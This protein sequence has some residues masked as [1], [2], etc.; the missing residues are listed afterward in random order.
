[1][2]VRSWGEFGCVTGCQGQCR[3]QYLPSNKSEMIYLLLLCCCCSY[4]GVWTMTRIPAK[5][6]GEKLTKQ[7]GGSGEDSCPPKIT[8]CSKRR[9]GWWGCWGFLE[10]GI[11]MYWCDRGWLRL[12]KG[13]VAGRAARSWKWSQLFDHTLQ[14]LK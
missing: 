4:L 14:S 11:G 7:L 2:A 6:T 5:C 3:E 1:M 10:L 9:G 12:Q 8:I 13:R